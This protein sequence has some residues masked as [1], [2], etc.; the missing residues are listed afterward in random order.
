MYLYFGERLKYLTQALDVEN[1][2]MTSLMIM[3]LQS[4]DVMDVYIVH[5]SS[6][7]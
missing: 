1:Y 5:H 7:R 4:G 2:L 6:Q 3:R